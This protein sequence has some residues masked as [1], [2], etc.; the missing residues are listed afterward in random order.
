LLDGKPASLEIF[1]HIVL[2]LKQELEF[3]ICKAYDQP[4]HEK[5]QAN[6]CLAVYKPVFEMD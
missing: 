2:R 5:G 4:G 1:N 3:V 6:A